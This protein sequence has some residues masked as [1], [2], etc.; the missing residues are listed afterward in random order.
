M[1]ILL[2]IG[3]RKLV[4]ESNVSDICGH[5]MSLKF[6]HNFSVKVSENGGD[7][8]SLFCLRAESGEKFGVKFDERSKVL[9]LKLDWQIFNQTDV[10]EKL[11]LQLLFLS[12]L[13][14]G[15]F[16]VHASAV[17]RNGKAYLIIGPTGSGKTSLSM[18]L[19]AR[20][21][22]NWIADD[23]VGLMI[24]KD[25]VFISQ[26]DD[27]LSFRKLPFSILSGHISIAAADKIRSRFTNIENPWVKTRPPLRCGD[28]GLKKPKLPI[29]MES[30]FFS[31]IVDSYHYCDKAPKS[32]AA[33]VVY[34]EFAKS[35]GGIGSYVL[36]NFGEIASQP[37]VLGTSRWN[38]IGSFVNRTVN[39]CQSYMVQGSLEQIL[40][41]ITSIILDNNDQR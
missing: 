20:K 9:S 32:Q 7:S 17:A 28:L 1:R 26:A 16:P 15:I 31:T 14:D 4:V 12:N 5:V 23:E 30:F 11:L 29:K 34:N 22:F 10:I 37:V 8:N 19:C 21:G 41:D 24:K 13:E 6:L 18:A 27:L 25:G 39:V 2:I 35:I 3:K 33:V 38:E 40:S 36:N